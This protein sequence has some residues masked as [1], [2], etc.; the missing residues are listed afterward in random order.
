MRFNSQS[1]TMPKL[2]KH[3]SVTGEAVAVARHIAIGRPQW[4]LL[5]ED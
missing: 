4:I 3:V 2:I 1:D 5:E